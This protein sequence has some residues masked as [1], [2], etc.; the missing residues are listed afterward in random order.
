MHFIR[1]G[2]GMSN[3]H[4]ICTIYNN[5]L[6]EY[7]FVHSWKLKSKQTKWDFTLPSKVR[8]Y[9]MLVIL[10][11]NI[12]NTLSSLNFKREKWLIDGC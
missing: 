7:I 1:I 2:D 5:K 6:S 8:E 11:V 10:N 4:M 12:E 9:I 3:K